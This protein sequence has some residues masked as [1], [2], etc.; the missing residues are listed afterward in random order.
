M[1]IVTGIVFYQSSCPV[2]SSEGAEGHE[3]YSTVPVL[4]L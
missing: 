3:W 2:E 4:L 1:K